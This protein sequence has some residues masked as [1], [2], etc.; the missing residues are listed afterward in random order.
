[1]AGTRNFPNPK[2]HHLSDRVAFGPFTKGHHHKGSKHSVRRPVW[3]IP[4]K[5]RASLWVIQ[6]Q[7]PSYLVRISSV[8][9]SCYLQS[10]IK[11]QRLF[12]NLQRL[13]PPKCKLIFRLHLVMGLVCSFSGFAIQGSYQANHRCH[14]GAIGMKRARW[15]FR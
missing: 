12:R 6:G 15:I 7:I 2:T 14:G 1:M 10:L 3:I 8:F 5:I 9:I 11:S 13:A 4:A